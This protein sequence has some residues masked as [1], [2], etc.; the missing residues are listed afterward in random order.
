MQD[1][2]V[3]SW[4]KGIKAKG[5]IRDQYHHIIDIAPTILDACGVEVMD[6]IDGIKQKPF[7]G[8]SM[9]YSFN[10]ADAEDMRKEQLYEMFGN[11][12]LYQDGWKAVSLHGQR[13]PWFLSS[14]TSF[15]D[16]VWEL[17][18]VAEDFSESTN[19]A[20]KYPD[21]L[22]ELKARFDEIAWETNVYPLYDDMVARMRYIKTSADGGRGELWVNGK[23]VDE[24]P[25]PKV[26]LSTFSLSEKFDV[27]RDAGTQVSKIYRGQSHFTGDLDKLTFR[28]TDFDESK[29]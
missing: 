29:K 16:D 26:H 17:Y 8:V 11:R 28:L 12:A 22:E 10:D 6:E 25:M 23:K 15:D 21:Q 20:D 18:H 4:P 5:E 2:L 3:V 14:V 27:G 24:C 13:M 19:V 7:D 9:R 1:A